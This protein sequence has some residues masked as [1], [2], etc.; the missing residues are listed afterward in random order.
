MKTIRV[1]LPVSS[2]ID[3]LNLAT[4]LMEKHLAEGDNSALSKLDWA[5]LRPAIDK[6]NQLQKDADAHRVQSKMCVEQRNALLNDIK[7]GIRS[8]RNILSGVRA[9]SLQ[10]LGEWGFSVIESTSTRRKTSEPVVVSTT[11]AAQAQ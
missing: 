7:V 4:K 1:P 5:T 11:G 3:M 9:G 10:S 6:A 8:S 2:S